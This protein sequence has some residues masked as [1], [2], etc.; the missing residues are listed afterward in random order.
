MVY[1][2]VNN[3]MIPD[4]MPYDL[5]FQVIDR[6]ESLANSF[7]LSYF[8]LQFQVPIKIQSTSFQGTTKVPLVCSVRLLNLYNGFGT[9]PKTALF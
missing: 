4:I 9:L 6:R 8:I 3:K 1:E 7:V 5:I 2:T